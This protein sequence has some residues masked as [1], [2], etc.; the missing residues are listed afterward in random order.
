MTAQLPFV[1]KVTIGSITSD[2]EAIICKIIKLLAFYDLDTKGPGIDDAV[3]YR[4]VNAVAG[5]NPLC[6]KIDRS[7]IEQACWT[8][9]WNPQYIHPLPTTKH[10]YEA[11]VLGDWGEPEY[12]GER[13]QSVKAFDKAFESMTISKRRQFSEAVIW[14]ADDAPHHPITNELANRTEILKL[15]GMATKKKAPA[16]AEAITNNPQI[17]STST[18]A[19]LKRVLSMLKHKP[20]N[21]L[22]FRAE[23]VPHPAGRVNDLRKMGYKILTKMVTATDSNGSSHRVAE[24]SLVED[25]C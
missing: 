1:K 9:D 11:L 4:A 16:K 19:Q 22:E 17:H 6:G 2:E 3:P 14:L 21:T 7:I 23:A 8:M 24:Y 18:I 13:P 25:C 5:H 12:W 20:V 10:L 15:A